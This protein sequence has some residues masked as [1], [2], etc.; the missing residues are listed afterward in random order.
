MT[1]IEKIKEGKVIAIVRGISSEQIRPLADAI[2]QGGVSCIEVTFDQSSEEAREDTLKSI[3]ILANEY[4]G[5]ICVG[6]GTVMNIKQVWEAIGA[7]AEYIISP[8]VD[9]RVIKKTKE[10]G[11]VSIPGALTPTEVALAYELGADIVKIFP[12]ANLGPSYIKALKSPL[13]HIPMTAVGGVNPENCVQF[14]EA[15]CIGVGCGGN[16]VSKKLVEE[17][18][19]DIISDTARAYME[20]LKNV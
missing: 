7:G 18:R 2:Y 16:L 9:E 6:A 19:F 10:L 5:K 1:T 12:A 11:K 14:F 15:G 4:A 3:S 17:G 13:K 20:A 8:N